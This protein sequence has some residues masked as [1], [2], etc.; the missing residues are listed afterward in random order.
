LEVDDHKP[1]LK[2]IILDFSSVN[3]VDVTSIQHLIDVRNQ[4]DRYTSPEVVEW[5]FASI[6]NR[7]TKRA[8]ASAGFGY[9]AS[10]HEIGEGKRWKPIF[11]VAE[12]GGFDS[13]ANAAEYEQN[14][15]ELKRGNT[16]DVETA[17][18]HSSV[19]DVEISKNNPH[20]HLT[21]IPR[22]V[23]VVHGVNR[24]LFH[25]DLTSALQSAVHNS[26]DVD[27]QSHELEVEGLKKL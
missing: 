18:S 12:I 8:L 4:L 7:W 20:E 10:A 21:A 5:H 2:A 19:D 27:P 25:I 15:E 17:H 22:K 24:P 23:A 6:N 16:R 26:Q 1:T 11:S 13:P 9:P 3:N 14:R